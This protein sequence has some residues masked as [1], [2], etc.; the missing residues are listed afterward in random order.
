MLNVVRL[1]ENWI[2]GAPCVLALGGFDG[3]HVGHREVVA[4]A[5]AFS[6]PVGIMTIVGGKGKGLFTLPERRDI[7]LRAGADFALELD[8]EKIKTMTADEF[9]RALTERFCVSAFVCGE[10]FRFGAG[11]QGNAESLKR[12]THVRVER[13][14]LCELDGEKVSSSLVKGRLAL[15]EVERANELLGESYFLLG[16]VVSG[17]KVGRTIGFPTANVAY[18]QDKFPLRFGV[19]ETRIAV[20]GKE[21]KGITNFG[22][23]PTFDD[24]SVWTESYLDG[25]S[26][27]LYGK[28]ICVKFVKYLRGIKRFEGAEALRGQLLEDIGR[29]RTND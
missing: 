25:F 28:K 11:A 2:E 10:D 1:T 24:E 21:Y 18:S 22:A 27:D 12:A 8:F 3:L 20:E 14:A 19:Y 16:E 5:K 4:R 9:A 23:R 17:R 7:F 26:G 6:L 15:G 29:I 13:L